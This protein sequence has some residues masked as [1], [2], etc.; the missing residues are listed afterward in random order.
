MRVLIDTCIWSLTLRRSARRNHFEEKQVEEVRELIREE[1]VVMI[2]PVRQE[3]LSGIANAQ[4]FDKLGTYL[5]AFPNEWIFDEDFVNA[6]RMYNICRG[7]GIQASPTD[8]LIC[9]IAKRIDAAVFTS[10]KNFQRYA[11]NIE[12]TLHDLRAKS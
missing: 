2:G 10:D 8:M 12:I 4:Q 6:A 5:S 11:E 7:Q 3:L 9:S 1:R